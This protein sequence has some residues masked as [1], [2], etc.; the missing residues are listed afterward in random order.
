MRHSSRSQRTKVNLKSTLHSQHSVV[1]FRYNDAYPFYHVS[2]AQF[3]YLIIDEKREK[4]AM[5][6]V[7]GLFIIGGSVVF[8]D[9]NSWMVYDDT[10]I[11]E[12]RISI[13]PAA[14]EWIYTWEN[15]QSDSLH[16]AQVHFKNK[17]IDETV[18]NIGFRLRGNTSWDSQK[19]SFKISFNTFVP[20]REFYGLDKMNLNGE[21]N[22]PSIIRSKICW[23]WF[24]DIGLITSRAAH[25]AVY[26]NDEYY[27]LYVSVEHIDD[28][29]VD[30]RFADPSGNLWKCLWPANLHYRSPNPEDYHP[31]H[32]AERPYELKTNE[33]EY[34]YSQLAR[35]IDI[36][37]NTPEADFVDSIEQILAVP[38]V[39][40]YFAMNIL[41]G[42]WDD[43]RFLQNNYYLYHEP[44]LDKFH[45]IPYDYDNTFGI[46]WFNTDWSTVDPYDYPVNDDDGRP[47][48]RI[49]EIPEYRNLYTH[50]LEFYSQHVTDLA[51]NE[52]RIDSLKAGITPWAEADLYRTFDYGFTNDDFHQSYTSK[53]ANGDHV[54]FGLKEFITAR[55]T[56]LP[57][58][59]EYLNSFPIIY[60]LDYQPRQPGPEDSIYVTVAAFSSTNI[61]AMEI[62]YHPGQLTV[63]E[64]YSMV[65]DPVSDTKILEAADRWTGVIPPLDA[66]DFGGFMVRVTGIETDLS[67]FPR[68]G[69]IE[70]RVVETQDNSLRI[71]EFLASNSYTN[72]DQDGEYDDWLELINLGEQAVVLS[73]LYLTDKPDNL[74]KWQFPPGSAAL[75]PGELLLV[76]CD[77]D[78]EQS[79]YHTNFKL[80][81]GG[82]FL[83]IVAED[84]V[85]VID[86]LRFGEQEEDVSFGRFPDGADSW[87]FFTAPTPGAPTS[88]E[89]EKLQ[90]GWQP[91][92]SC[93][94]ISPIHSTQSPPF[95]I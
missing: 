63:T 4:V 76:W 44:A 95:N 78:E 68:T 92:F 6:A 80:S 47:L 33:E 5:L 54:K 75:E 15:R 46:D 83:A 39:L 38:E 14:L 30:K 58:Q 77:E 13:D 51:L 34:D 11:A 9:D 25:A 86:S 57:D 64:Y 16:L 67:R 85:S 60:H 19:K 94:A 55:N 24:N 53:P 7:V 28:E 10:E 8:A 93:S 31:Y 81:A 61:P 45:L 3:A 27:G 88:S 62:Q 20:G 41:T 22:D 35:L 26:I 90:T 84:G 66:G 42:S 74:T 36:L 37:N 50:M 71:N 79:G 72:T 40:K 43:Y 48:L 2:D 87:Q 91:G 29:F 1:F 70:I 82:E 89:T 12:I 17:Y 73:G 65:P 21:H 56:S 69:L 59:L 18:E 32:D 49:L 52:A 23:D